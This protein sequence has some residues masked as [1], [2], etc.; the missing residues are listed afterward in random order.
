MPVGTGTAPASPSSHEGPKAEALVEEPRIFDGFTFA[1]Q[2]QGPAEIERLP[3]E[4]QG[5]PAPERGIVVRMIPRER[6]R[7]ELFQACPRRVKRARPLLK[8][9]RRLRACLPRHRT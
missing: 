8:Q 1:D 5:T 7:E 9:P 4:I 6:R 3:F 2:T